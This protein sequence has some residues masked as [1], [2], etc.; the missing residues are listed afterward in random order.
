MIPHNSFYRNSILL[1]P[2][3]IVQKLPERQSVE[4]ICNNPTAQ[5]G[6]AFINLQQGGTG[7]NNFHLGIAVVN[8]FYFTGPS[9]IIV[10][11][12]QIKEFAALFGKFIS[13]IEQ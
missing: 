12:I 5:I 4:L 10:N 7:K 11:L 9:N 8:V 3:F 1:N 6:F 2:V 13:K